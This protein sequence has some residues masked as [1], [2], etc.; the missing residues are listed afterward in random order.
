MTRCIALVLLLAMALS[1]TSCI[2]EPG[3]GP[4]HDRWCGWHPDRCH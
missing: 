2:V 1:T 3:P 4:E